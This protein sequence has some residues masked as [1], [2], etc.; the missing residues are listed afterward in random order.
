MIKKL[1]NPTIL[2]MQ[3]IIEMPMPQNKRDLEVYIATHFCKVYSATKTCQ[4]EVQSPMNPP[5]PDIK[6]CLDDKPLYIELTELV[7]KKQMELNAYAQ[8]FEEYFIKMFN[9]KVNLP[10]DIHIDVISFDLDVRNVPKIKVKKEQKTIELYVD[11][12]V[13]KLKI[14]S[15]LRAGEWKYFPRKS[16]RPFIEFRITKLPAMFYSQGGVN[17]SLQGINTI[18]AT[19]SDNLLCCSVESKNKCRYHIKKEQLWLLVYSFRHF[20]IDLKDP[21]IKNLHTRLEQS[22]TQFHQIWYFWPSPTDSGIFF[23]LWPK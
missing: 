6:C 15:N 12:I 21:A 5:Y 10:S 23:R 9:Q 1:S 3:G 11:E 17:V 20:P 2:T 14:C 16:V 7:S 8:K 13:R 19:E 22:S 18:E 4:L